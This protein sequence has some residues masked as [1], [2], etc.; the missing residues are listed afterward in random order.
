MASLALRKKSRHIRKGELPTAAARPLGGLSS[1][2]DNSPHLIKANRIHMKKILEVI[3]I[4]KYRK[5]R[6]RFAP[7]G[8]GP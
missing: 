5:N 8:V 4:L 7:W 2:M 3:V 6:R 1:A